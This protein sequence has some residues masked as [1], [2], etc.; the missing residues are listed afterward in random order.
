MTLP[1]DSH[2]MFTVQTA[3]DAELVAAALAGERSAFGH[4]V[5]RY[6]RLLCSVAYSA[7]GQLSQ[8]EDLAQEA[9]VDAWRQLGSLREPEKLRSWLCAILRFKVSRLRRA[10][11]REPVRRAEALDV[12]AEVQSDD[13]TAPALAIEKEEQALLWS[14]LE[15]VPE[16]YREPLIL[17]YREHRS[18]E[19]VAAALELT[20]DNVKQRLARG[21]KILQEQ[22]LSFVEGAL[23]RSTPGKLFTLGVL[24]ALPE[25]GT[26][27]KAAGLGVLAAHSGMI[28]KSASIV[29]LISSFTGIATTIL[30]LRANLDQAR[31]P[32]ERRAVVKITLLCLSS[33]LGGMGV[34]YALQVSALRWWDHRAT[35]AVA[36]LVVV[37]AVLAGW[38]ILILRLMRNQRAL[39]SA[40]RRRHPDLFA[41][42]SDAVG[43]ASN[44]YRS[45]RTFLGVP[46]VHARFSC[47]DLHEPPVFGWFAA[48]DRAIGLL[49]AW[50]GLAVA[51]V[52]VGAVSIGLFSVGSVAAG[53]IALGNF[54]VGGFAVGCA[55]IGYH[56]FTWLFGLGW[57]SAAGGGFEIARLAAVGPIAFAA[58]ANDPVAWEYF[59]SPN[60]ERNKAVILTVM[61]LL[62]LLP[63]VYYA[64]AVRQRMRRKK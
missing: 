27:A 13:A 33:V 48:G 56:T 47:P 2:P 40:E 17:Y 28:A 4:I 59:A 39:R 20:E 43:S 15:R 58:H 46:L 1:P 44:E 23:S 10:D 16:N 57:Q 26:P 19:H 31:T 50:G 38:P 60:A 63:V 3:T 41:D 61:V 62:S 22:V 30:T 42:P 64:R 5:E 34:L 9:F 37:L 35:L 51:P 6:Q 18:I 32:L 7:T 45:A 24:A 53:V 49:V 11:G 8:S 52:S 14:A 21:R 54:S 12:A 36:A 55:S 29:G 25:I